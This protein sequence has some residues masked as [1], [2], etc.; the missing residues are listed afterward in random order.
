MQL[1]QIGDIDVAG[2][3]A[4]YMGLVT[5]PTNSVSKELAVFPELSFSYLVSIRPNL[6]LMMLKS[7]RLFCMRLI[8][9]GY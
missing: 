4:A 9:T 7:A 3:G 6:L 2:V 5:D 1:Y 8:R